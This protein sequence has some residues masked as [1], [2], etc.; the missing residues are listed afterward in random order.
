MNRN[1]FLKTSL[2]IATF[3]RGTLGRRQDCKKAVHKHLDERKRRLEIDSEAG[4]YRFHKLSN[5]RLLFLRN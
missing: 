3:L 5:G 1:A 4:D 2:A